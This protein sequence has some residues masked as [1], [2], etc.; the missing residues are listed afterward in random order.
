MCFQKGFH[1]LNLMILA[2][3]D[4]QQDAL[5][6]AIWVTFVRQVGAEKISR[7]DQGLGCIDSILVMGDHLMNEQG[8][9]LRCLDTCDDMV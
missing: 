7:L 8:R 2:G 1:E 9:V 6:N 5:E 4:F 3:H